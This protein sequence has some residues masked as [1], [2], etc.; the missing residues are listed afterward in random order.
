MYNVGVKNVEEWLI[1]GVLVDVLVNL[2]DEEKVDLLVVGNVG[3]SMIVG[4]LFGLVLVNVLCWVK[5][6]VLI[7]Y[8]I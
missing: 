4:W 1:V 3:L 6:D 2:V 8:I 5:V 7:V